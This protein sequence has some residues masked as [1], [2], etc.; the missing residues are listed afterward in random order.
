MLVLLLILSLG[1]FAGP[2]GAKQL[3]ARLE[4]RYRAAKTLQ[5]TF[6]EQYEENGRVVRAESGTAY[7]RRPGRMRW[8]YAAPEKNVF[9]VDG[10]TAWFYVPSDH[11][12]TRVPA[13]ESTDLRTPL[14]LL[15]GEMKV[16]RVCSRVWLAEEKP[17]NENDA[18]LQC[19]L[20]G[21]EAGRSKWPS[22]SSGA[23]GTASR[24]SI[25][26]EIGRASG[27]L[28]RLVLRRADGVTID[29]RFQNWR[30]DPPVP[31]V[32]FHFQVPPGVAIVN[33]ELPAEQSS[34]H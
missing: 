25:I 11:T 23:E 24:D 3:I 27:D 22:A 13:K 14:A 28:E 32:M 17:Q 6:L 12:V 26:F 30:M 1:S 2:D 33:G 29:F 9:L 16:S 5:A 19:A 18:V 15:A 31:E 7:F 34:M 21:E 10:K 20:R 4:A 8:E